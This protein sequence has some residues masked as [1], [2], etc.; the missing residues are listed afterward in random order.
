MNSQG[1]TWALSELASITTLDEQSRAH[2]QAVIAWLEG[3]ECMAQ[4]RESAT[5]D[6]YA[7][8]ASPAP[9][10]EVCA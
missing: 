10:K 8:F 5:R 7:A 1:I 9:V 3:E 4:E 6:G 2:V